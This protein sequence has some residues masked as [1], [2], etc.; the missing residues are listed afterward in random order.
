MYMKTIRMILVAAA[1]LA[2]AS[3]EKPSGVSENAHDAQLKAVVEQYVP[4]VIYKI[5][6]NLADASEQLYTKIAAMKEAGTYTQ[7]QID[8]VC[9]TFLEARKWWEQS[10]AFLYGAATT[11]GIDPHIDS[12]PL[13]KDKLAKSLSNAETIADLAQDG[14]GAVDEVG[15]ASLG[16]HGIEFIFFREGK[17]RTAAELNAE[18]DDEAF[19]GRHVT[20]KSEIIFAVA[21]AED[22]RNYCFELQ[23]AWD[24]ACPE[25]RR[26]MVEDELELNTTMVNGLTYGENLLKTGQAGSTYRG[27]PE[28]VSGILVAG[29]SNIC[30]EV[31]N[32]KIGTAHYVSSSDYDPDYIESPYSKKSYEDFK[33]NILSIQ[34]SL[35]GAQGAAAPLGNSIAS[36]LK[37]NG[38]GKADAM[39]SALVA[40]IKSL[41]DAMAKG[42][43]VDNPSSAEA[44]VC[45]DRINEL[46][47][48]LNEAADWISKL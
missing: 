27:W 9:T 12:W 48:L 20:G 35:Y 19:S 45:I 22:L 6:G 7:A 3:C 40:A 2:A 38:W 33:D 16:F 46:D 32:T 26:T 30:N 25:A 23:A 36:F 42:A 41:D 28:A 24:P 5:Y 14:A 34:Y 13:D 37:N 1:C 11:Y 18:E 47:A 15:A 29:C 4:G 31:A 39:Q 10:E 17:N 44:G 43:F 8:G 21:V